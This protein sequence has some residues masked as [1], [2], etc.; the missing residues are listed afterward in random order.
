[1]ASKRVAIYPGT[2]DPVTNG[3]LDIVSRATAMCDELII[4]VSRNSSKS[5]L[6][7]LNERLDMLQAALRLKRYPVKVRVETFSGLLV[8]FAQK[9]GV[10]TLVRGLRAVSDFEYEFQM[11][12]MNRHQSEHV[13][14]VFLMPDEK[15]VYLS[16][17][18]VK[19]VAKLNGDLKAFLPAPVLAAVKKKFPPFA[20]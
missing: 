13:E 11:A 6:F 3:H 17:S 19:E 5:T 12:L 8:R 4:A 10:R 18:M 16:S 7:S 2:F 15:Y 9:K 20:K 1:M 14:T